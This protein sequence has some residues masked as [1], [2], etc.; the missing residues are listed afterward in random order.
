[1]NKQL[2]LL[3]L[4]IFIHASMLEDRPSAIRCGPGNDG[5]IFWAHSATTT[6]NSFY[7]QI[8]EKDY[9]VVAF[10]PDGTYHN[11][12]GLSSARSGC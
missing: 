10:K 3:T 8:W 1:M 4:V 6:E 7:F 9:R 12:S 11:G 2:F 5:S